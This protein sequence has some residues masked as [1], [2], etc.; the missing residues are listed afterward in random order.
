[1]M[2]S[3][4]ITKRADSATR[5]SRLPIPFPV[6]IKLV[7]NISYLHSSVTH[8]TLPRHLTVVIVVVGF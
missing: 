4:V 8:G 3:V 6:P 2:M 7:L 1:M 5:R